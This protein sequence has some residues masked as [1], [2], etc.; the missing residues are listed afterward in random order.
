MEVE[1]DYVNG[2]LVADEVEFEESIELESIATVLD[3]TTLTLNGLPGITVKVNETTELDSAVNSLADFNGAF[4]S[5]RGRLD[6][7]GV[8]VIASSI[9]LIEAAPVANGTYE[10]KLQGPSDALTENPDIVIL[11][12]TVDT[13]S[14]GFNQFLDTNDVTIGRAVF[15]ASVTEGRLLEVKGEFTMTDGTPGP[16]TWFETEL[17]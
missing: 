17:E 15:F 16:I 14:W 6:G 10:A 3:S 11:G 2:V 12:I 8:N 1:G 5:V 7:M 4:V 9:E 13:S